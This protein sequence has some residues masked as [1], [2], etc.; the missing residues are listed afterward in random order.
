MPSPRLRR[1]RLP[2][3]SA[4]LAAGLA[5]CNVDLDSGDP[6]QDMTP[7]TPAVPKTLE[8]LLRSACAT[9]TAPTERVP[10][11]M[12]FILDGSGS[13][14]QQGKWEA[15]TASLTGIFDDF[16]AQASPSF[17]AGLTI[18]ADRNDKTI[19]DFWAG[20]YDKMDVPVGFVST[21]QADRMKAR[22]RGTAPYLGTPT[23]EVLSGQLPALGSFPPALP[24][25]PGG[26]RV[27]V[28]ITDGVPDPDMPAGRNE[29][30]WSLDIVGKYA[31]GMGGAGQPPI[32]TF[33]IGVGPFPGAAEVEYSPSF[34]GDLAVA[35]GTR[36]TATCDPHEQKDE[37]ALCYLQVTPPKTGTPSKEE[38][39]RLTARFVAAIDKVRGDAALCE[40][41]LKRRDTDLLL[42]PANINVFYTDDKGQ[43]SLIPKGDS[44]GWSY[45]DP[46]DPKRVL[47]HGEACD[48]VK[49]DKSGVVTIIIGCASIVLP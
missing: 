37:G 35:G 40:Y 41:T 32:N 9:G 43:R 31:R 8:E 1:S 36:Q 12:L 45:D 4:A 47:L 21:E 27:A 29:V 42:D 23:Y 19:S 3:L 26:R 25:L 20:P 38:I 7:M 10:V 44:S 2:L 14:R 49:A 11:Y 15:A 34:L 22:I 17:G 6:S 28:F 48:R 39:Q 13:M 18:F 46:K 30:P 5:G 33:V 24:L 16:A